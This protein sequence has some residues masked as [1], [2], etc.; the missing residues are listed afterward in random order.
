MAREIVQGRQVLERD[1][2]LLTSV[3]WRCQLGPQQGHRASDHASG[4]RSASPRGEELTFS[5]YRSA[6]ARSQR[7]ESE[8]AAKGHERGGEDGAGT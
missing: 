4:L 3:P 8:G 1:A 7:D 6:N 5:K 2:F